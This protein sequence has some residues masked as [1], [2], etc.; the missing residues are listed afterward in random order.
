[1]R[2]SLRTRVTAEFVGTALLAAVVLGSGIMAERL[3]GGT[4]VEALVSTLA[5]VIVLVILIV[6]LMPV[7]G[8]HFNPAFSLALAWEGRFSWREVPVYLVAQCAGA[9]AGVAAAHGLLGMPLLSLASRPRNGTVQ[10]LSELAA[11]FGLASVLWV[12]LRVRPAM[13]AYAIGVYVFAASIFTPSGCFA[14]PALT[15]ARSASDTVVGIRPTDVLAFVIA[16]IVGALAA[17]ALYRRMA[18]DRNDGRKLAE[19]VAESEAE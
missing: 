17:T 2:L 19:A 7:S 13:I 3:A 16:Q 1:M 5:T 18:T 12:C 14:N 11:T 15:L 10:L 4:P 6:T 8:A 9:L